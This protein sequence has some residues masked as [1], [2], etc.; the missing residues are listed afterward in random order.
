MPQIY[1]FNFFLYPEKITSVLSQFDDWEFID[2]KLKNADQT[3][4][5]AWCY[6][7][8]KHYSPFIVGLDYNYIKSHDL[9]KQIV[10]QIVKQANNIGKK[11]IY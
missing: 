3:I 4:A 8:D 11:T 5:T 7:G 2:I 10:F 1:G 9:Y 6:I